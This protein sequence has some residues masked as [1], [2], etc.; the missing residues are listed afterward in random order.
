MSTHRHTLLLGKVLSNVMALE[1]AM[2]AALAARPGA[3]RVHDLGSVD[4]LSLPE[5][6][7]L[8]ESEITKFSYFSTVLESYNSYARSE[9]RREID[10]GI[11][12]LR[13]LI[14]HGTILG[15]IGGQPRLLKFSKPR[16]GRVQILVN[17]EMTEEWLCGQLQRTLKALLIVAE[18]TPGFRFEPGAA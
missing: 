3:P 14:A 4:L 2:R 7:D 18:D 13:N 11:L 12:E 6:S 9:R 16:S 17:Q 10:V 8:P 15:A 5:G 1:V